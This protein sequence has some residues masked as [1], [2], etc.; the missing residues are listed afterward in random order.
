M[1]RPHQVAERMQISRGCF[2]M[3][4]MQAFRLTQQEVCGCGVDIQSEDL[5]EPSYCCA[6][7]SMH[8]HGVL[9]RAASSQ[10]GGGFSVDAGVRI[11][12]AD[13]AWLERRL[14]YCARPPSGTNFR[15]RMRTVIRQDMSWAILSTSPSWASLA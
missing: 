13:R 9:E 2:L 6:V 4:A 10:H 5:R 12:A 8:P 15:R 7:A 1:V 3:G 11:E 14:R